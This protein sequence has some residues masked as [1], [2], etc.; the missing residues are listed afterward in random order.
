MTYR[1]SGI[2]PERF[3]RFF[4]LPYAD[5]AAEGIVRVRADAKPGFP[6]RVTLEDAE[7]GE[8][9]L[10]INH[11]SHDVAT[12]YRSAYAIYVREGAGEA[13][14]IEDGL[15]AVF[16]NRPIA[17]RAF[18]SAGMLRGA[19]LALANDADARIREL[20]GREEIAYI[21]AH[22]AAHGCFAARVDRT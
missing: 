20:F 17:L 19:S 8:T 1:I 6:C 16:A 10:L 14:V 21:H 9:L 2:A 5:L 22:N 7:P 13:A 11:V 12:P 15:P 3:A 4:G 18:D